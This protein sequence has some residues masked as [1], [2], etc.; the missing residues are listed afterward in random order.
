MKAP[1]SERTFGSC[2]FCRMIVFYAKLT[3]GLMTARQR[4]LERRFESMGGLQQLPPGGAGAHSTM[5][6]TTSPNLEVRSGRRRR[7]E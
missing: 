5:S 2:E 1:S 6:A 3:G 4:F 7:E